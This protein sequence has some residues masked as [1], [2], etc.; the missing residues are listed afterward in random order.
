[1][2]P[3]I[4][5]NKLCCSDGMRGF[6]EACPP[7]SPPL[8]VMRLGERFLERLVVV[9][10]QSAKGSVRRSPVGRLALGL[11]CSAAAAVLRR[12]RRALGTGG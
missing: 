6:Y 8:R 10:A 4:H 2:A 12:T 11:G 9:S 7:S 3:K 1:M 5:P